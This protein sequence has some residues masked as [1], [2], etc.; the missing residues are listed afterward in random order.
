MTILRSL[1]PALALGAGLAGPATAADDLQWLEPPHETKALEWARQAT[2]RTRAGLGALPVHA[3]VSRELADALVQAPAEPDQYLLGER[4]LRVYRDAEHPYGLLQAAPRDAQGRAGQWRT[5]LDVAALREREGVPFELQAYDLGSSCLAPAYARCLLRLAPGGGDEVEIR[6]F[7][8]GRGDFV[9]DGFRVPRSRAFA[10]WMGPDQVMVGHTLG[11]APKSLAG[12]PTAFGLWTRG[13]PLA[14]VR[15]VY[16]GKTGDAIVQ[17]AGVGTGAS[18]QAVL[19][20]A[21]DY[22]TFEV[23]LVDGDGQVRVLPLPQTLK[24]FGVLATSR[25]HVLL[26]LA[27]DATLEGRAYPAETVIAYAADPAV[28]EGRR[29]SAVYAPADGEFVDAGFGGLAASGEEVFLVVNRHLRQRVLAARPQGDGWTVRPLQEVAAGDT[30]TLRADA[31]DRDELAL[32][33]TGFLTPRSQYLVRDGGQPLLLAQDPAVMDAS[34]FVTEIANAI[35]RDG[36]DVD[37]FL[38]RPKTAAEGPQPLLMTGYGAF[39]ISLRPGYFDAVVGGPAL[40]LWLQRGGSVAIPAMRGGGERGAAWHQA[41]LREKRQNSYDDFIAVTEQL[42]ATGFTRPE[43][44]GIFGMSNG[45]L[46]TA[47][48]GTQRPDLFGAVVSDVPLTDLIRMRHMGMGAAWMN[49][50]GDPDV[51]QQAAAMLAYSPYQNVRKGTAYPPFLVTISTED[52]RVGP[53]HARKFAHRLADAGATT[54]FYEDE[55]G[56]HGV[57]DAFRNPELMALRMSF[58]ID[59]LIDGG[60]G[61]H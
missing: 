3:A 16:Q 20:R 26:Q 61:S 39:G 34:G 29:I 25:R 59:R 51:P 58:L 12:W 45:G 42:I 5:V 10:E 49:E 46:L 28:P 8:L 43:R 56:G 52:N 50:Y 7:D 22:S 17:L 19:T 14:D 55:E 57:S 2:D 11:D 35:S 13:Q 4:A 48:L 32:S 31:R 18:A 23:S 47:T 1:L 15:P 38:L 44:I 54:Y 36:T 60:T 9:E 37:Y 27:A 40:K 33:V 30:A 41:A 24:A 21:I 6:E 53:G